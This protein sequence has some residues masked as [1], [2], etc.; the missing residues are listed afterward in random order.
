ME[1]FLIFAL[2][3]IAGVVGHATLLVLRIRRL[4][5]DVP[6][7]KRLLE[8]ETDNDTTPTAADSRLRLRLERHNDVL[9]TFRVDDGTFV[10]QGADL[11]QLQQHLEQRYPGQAAVV[12]EGDADVL[13]WLKTQNKTQTQ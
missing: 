4:L 2:G 10:A 6:E 3:V 8:G 13:E 9:Y 12:T 11:A 1:L 5:R 7:L